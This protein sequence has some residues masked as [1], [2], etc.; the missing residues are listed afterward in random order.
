MSSSIPL[1]FKDIKAPCSTISPYLMKTK[2]L[3]ACVVVFEFDR[4]SKTDFVHIQS[5]HSSSITLI[6]KGTQEPV[7]CISL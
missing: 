2:L 6:S 4:F 1:G 7:F 5:I 3:F